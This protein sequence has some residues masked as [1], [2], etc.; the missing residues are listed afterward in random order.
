MGDGGGVVVVS[1]GHVGGTRGSCSVS[2]AADVLGMIVVPAMRAV[3]GG[4]EMRMCL[5]R[6]GVGGE[7][8]EWM[9]GLG[10]GY[11]NH[12]KT[13]SVI[14]VCLCLGCGGVGGVG[15]EWVGG[16]DEGLVRWDGVMS[17]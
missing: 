4:C 3:G 2:S 13:G 14:D 8:G 12:V 5:P 15:G 16:L 17:V 1:A 10:L 6:G 7:G 9:T 11:T